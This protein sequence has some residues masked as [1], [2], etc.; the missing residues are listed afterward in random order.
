MSRDN[1]VLVVQT[2]WTNSHKENIGIL[3]GRRKVNIENSKR[4]VL[5][6]KKESMGK[7]TTNCPHQHKRLLTPTI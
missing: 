4:K 2:I 5:E 3:W 7:R 1:H 6:A